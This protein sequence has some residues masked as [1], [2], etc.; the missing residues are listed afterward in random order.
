MKSATKRLFID[1]IGI[2]IGT[3]IFFIAIPPCAIY[4]GALEFCLSIV[5]GY[6]LATRS[7]IRQWRYGI[8]P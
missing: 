6:K 4:L 2:I 3:L 8:D 1:R 5:D 7:F